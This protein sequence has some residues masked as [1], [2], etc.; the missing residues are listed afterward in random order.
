MA[1]TTA[2]G[3]AALGRELLKPLSAAAAAIALACAGLA[4]T[5]QFPSA[6]PFVAIAVLAV[7]AFAAWM[8]LNQ[9]YEWSLAVLMLYLG[10]ADGYLKLR[11]GSSHATLLRDVLLY[12]IAAGAL[13]RMAVRREAVS[14]PP[15]AGWVIAWVL[16]VAIQIAN[17]ANG[18]LSHSLASVRPHA[19]W[20]P[21]FFLGYVAVRSRK[22]IRVF[23]LLLVAI[24]AVNGVVSLVQANLTPEQLSG[25]GPGY[26]RAINGEGENSVSA[27]G[28]SDSEGESHNRPFALGG[29]SGFGGTMG[30][31]AISAALALLALSRRPGLRILTALL[32]AGTVL[33]VAT[34][35]SRTAVL[36]SV[37]AVFAFAGLTVTSRAGLRTVFAVGLAVVVVYATLG[38]L[39]GGAEKGAFDRYESISSPG[40]AVSTA[41]DYRRET[42]SKVPRYAVEHPLGAGFGRSGPAGS[43]AGGP[44][45]GGLDAESEPTYLLIELGIP[46]LLVMLGFNLT[47]F[48]LGITRIRRIA[49]RELRILLTGV[50]APL[51]AIFVTWFVGVA[52]ATV[53]SSPYLWFSAGLLSYWLLGDGYRSVAQLRPSQPDVVKAPAPALSGV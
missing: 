24:A 40:E 8:F 26:Q 33:A 3:P 1:T 46:G 49:D 5:V 48:Y 20:V 41:Y 35:A 15:L 21:L 12:A 51:F 23:L 38:A 34:S 32:A 18:T 39:T 52:T 6:T 16:V 44:V 45:G 4:I 7:L 28:F 30:L 25:W 22:R 11:T 47:L 31:I 14:L 50:T 53:P 9:R 13:I 10:L 2:S 42:L 27:R 29:D 17:P 36:G 37:V 19:E 43:V